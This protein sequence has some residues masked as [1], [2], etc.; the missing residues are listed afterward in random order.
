VGRGPGWSLVRLQPKVADPEYRSM[1][2]EMAKKWR[3]AADAVEA[4]NPYGVRLP[5]WV[6]K[7]S[8]K[9]DA[10]EQANTGATMGF[11]WDLQ[12][13]AMRDYF[14]HKHLPEIFDANSLLNV[15]NFV[16]GCHP[17]TNTSY[18]SGVGTNSPLMAYGFNRDD[19]SYI[20]GGVISGASFV[21]PEF[22]ELKNF[23]YHFN[24]TE[25]VIHG[26]GSYIFDVLAAQ[27][28]LEH[29]AD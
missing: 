6:L 23:P 22:M 8:W 2:L 4:S 16:L 18:V 25:Y 11:G 27:W 28:I 19:Y 20:P 1:V 21:R 12:S 15:V 7:A 14:Y 17:A 9:L 26:A 24:Q 5:A 10:P 13:Y 29:Q 3:A